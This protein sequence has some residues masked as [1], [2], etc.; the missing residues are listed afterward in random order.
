MI[1]LPQS[2]L[3]CKIPLPQR[4]EVSVAQRLSAWR[5]RL[6]VRQGLEH[7]CLPR[8]FRF[9]GRHRIEVAA[10]ALVIRQS[11]P[12]CSQTPRP[13]DK[14]VVGLRIENG[15]QRDGPL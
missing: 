8:R 5:A 7:S 2:H 9:T 4:L 1:A 13:L 15:A 6:K 12:M 10:F 3:R 11:A 14:E